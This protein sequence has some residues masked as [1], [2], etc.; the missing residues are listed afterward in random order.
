VG[1]CYDLIVWIEEKPGT[2]EANERASLGRALK[3]E[4]RLWR[5]K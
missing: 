2:F 4:E 5:G 1:F 3:H